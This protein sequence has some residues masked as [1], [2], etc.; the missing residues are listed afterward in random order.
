MTVQVKSDEL[1]AAARKLRDEA[2]ETLRKAGLQ[3]RVPE[4]QYGVEQA[5]DTYTTAA[6]YREYATAMEQE[7]RVLEEAARQLADALEQTANDYDASDARA[8]S[9]LRVGGHP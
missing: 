9:A 6:A 2:A 3:M 7:F 1:R 5:F 8:A 4:K